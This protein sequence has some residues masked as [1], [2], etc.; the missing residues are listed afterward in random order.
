MQTIAVY[1]QWCESEK[2]IT[3]PLV[4]WLLLKLPDWVQVELP[5]NKRNN[6]LDI[7]SR[8]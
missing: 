5:S 8:I 2:D 6:P 3:Y 7:T 1:I 4:S